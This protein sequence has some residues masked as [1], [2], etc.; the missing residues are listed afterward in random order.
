MILSYNHFGKNKTELYLDLHFAYCQKYLLIKCGL[1]TIEGQ[2][3]SKANYGVLNSPKKT[4]VGI[5][6]ST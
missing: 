4:N 3:I 2:A 1:T 5:I 6:L